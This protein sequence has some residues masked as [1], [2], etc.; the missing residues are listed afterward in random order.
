MNEK[1]IENIIKSLKAKAIT[2]EALGSK[3]A[4]QSYDKGFHNGNIEGLEEAIK[5]LEGLLGYHI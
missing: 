5:G 4:A 1:D 2:S 3:L